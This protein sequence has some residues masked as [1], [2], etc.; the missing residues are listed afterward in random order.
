VSPFQGKGIRLDP[1]PRAKGP[2]LSHSAPLGR[3]LPMNHASVAAG[4]SPAVEGGVSPPG[5][6][7][8][9]W[10]VGRSFSNRVLSRWSFLASL[11]HGARSKCIGP[12]SDLVRFHPT[13]S[14]PGPRPDHS[15][16]PTLSQRTS[17]TAIGLAASVLSG[18]V[19]DWDGG[20]P[21]FL[22]VALGGAAT[23]HATRSPAC[24]SLQ[25]AVKVSVACV[26]FASGL[27]CCSAP[28]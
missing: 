8:G 11:R 21:R 15:G 12:L 4:V 17:K 25:T 10:A 26:D 1:I 2:G 7:S 18:G 14:P 20:G 16:P 6:P 24:P 23:D 13:P 27:L 22:A 5:I 3:P 19:G 9:S 28:G